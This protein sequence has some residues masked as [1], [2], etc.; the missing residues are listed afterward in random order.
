MSDNTAGNQ[1]ALEKMALGE[2]LFEDH[3]VLLSILSH[4]ESVT[5]LFAGG[6]QVG[7]PGMCLRD[8][9]ASGNAEPSWYERAKAHLGSS[10]CQSG[11]L[12]IWTTIL[13]IYADNHDI[14]D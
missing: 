6:L 7:F 3:P 13:M 4:S 8:D 1:M 14:Y 11:W 10:Q 12:A 5:L 2:T 9:C